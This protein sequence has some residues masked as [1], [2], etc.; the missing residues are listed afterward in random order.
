M[1]RLE[2]FAEGRPLPR[3][4]TLH[5]RIADDDDLLVLAFVRMGGESLPWA[6]GVTHPHAEP[7]TFTVPD[8]RDRDRVGEMLIGLAPL[9]AAHLDH[10]DYSGRAFTSDDDAESVSLRQLW[11]PNG[12]HVQML[13]MLNMRYTFARA[14]DPTRA[15]L[16]RMLGRLSGFLFREAARPGEATLVDASAAIR[17]AYTFPA[18]DLRQQ[19]VGLLLA[20]LDTPGSGADRAA[21]AEKAERLSVSTSMDPQVERDALE[22]HVDRHLKA[23][24]EGKKRDMRRSEREIA[25][26]LDEE[27][28]RRLELTVRAI[29]LLRRDGRPVNAGAEALAVQSTKARQSDYLWFEEQLI[30]RGEGNIFPTSPET[31]KDRRSGAARYH[32]LSSAAEEVEAVLVHHDAELQEDAITSGDAIKGTIV[33]VE[34]RAPAG[35]RAVTPVWVLEAPSAAP[36]RLRKGSGV[37]VAGVPS[38]SGTILSVNQRAGTRELELRI[39][40]W[41]RKPDERRHPQFAHVPA[42]D[43]SSL[44]GTEV[45]LLSASMSGIGRLKSTRV[46]DQSGPGAWLTHGV[47]NSPTRRRRPTRADVLD[48]IDGLRKS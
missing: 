47:G 1:R 12:S 42:A 44:E 21:A 39:D 25:A 7:V 29:E 19:H 43:D 8:A 2:A 46:R 11:V 45:V 27:L 37:C 30:S 17:E 48:E 23:R 32:R 31:D 3:G 28:Y 5:L 40:G 4:S 24:R 38:R 20:L 22:P 16:L 13:H 41:K 34:D 35:S 6:I 10:P 33:K 9:L 18:D 26:I 15:M 36:M 14:G